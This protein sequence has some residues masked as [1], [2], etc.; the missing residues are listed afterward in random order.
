MSLE[1]S[2]PV[3]YER[4]GPTFLAEQPST[5]PP[6]K[7]GSLEWDEMYNYLMARL[8]MLQNWR[9]SWWE[10]WALLAAYILP[11]RIS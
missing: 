6:Q 5:P 8:T 4:A 10:H 3:N 11:R 7:Q 9:I 1:A 2:D